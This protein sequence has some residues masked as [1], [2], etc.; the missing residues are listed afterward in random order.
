MRNILPYDIK[1][2]F[3]Y[4]CHL[5]FHTSSTAQTSHFCDK[6][7]AEKLETVNERAVPFVLRDKLT[8]YEELMGTKIT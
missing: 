6:G 3:T 4:I 2:I 5:L 8:P 1:R 7:S